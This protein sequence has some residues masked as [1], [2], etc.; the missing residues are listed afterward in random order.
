MTDPRPTALLI[1]DLDGTVRHGRDEL[2]RYVNGPDD[3]VIFP[4]AI[5][6]MRAWKA[7]GGRIIGA[8]NQGGVALGIIT[9]RD[10]QAAIDRTHALTDRLFDHLAFCPHHP[11]ATQPF[12]ARCWC[13]KPRP[14][15]VIEAATML[16]QR[17]PDEFYPPNLAVMVGDRLEDKGCAD[18]IDI[19]FMW[20]EDWRAG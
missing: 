11:Q 20:A 5:E 18:S 17:F 1:L 3:V 6:K 15:L 2:G 16:R 8:S 13:R 4:A 12:M 7:D 19:P 9:H 14:G 10:A